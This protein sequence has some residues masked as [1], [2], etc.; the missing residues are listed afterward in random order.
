M[1]ASMS[2]KMMTKAKGD[3]RMSRSQWTSTPRTARVVGIA[4]GLALL[5]GCASS[6]REAPPAPEGAAA[7]QAE[8]PQEVR[9]EA[10]Q[11]AAVREAYERGVRDVL[12]DYRGRMRASE[13]FVY[14]PPVIEYV[15]MPAEIRSG[16]LYPSRSEP[17][18]I[19]PGG[20]RSQQGITVPATRR[21]EGP[22]GG[23]SE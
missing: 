21:D 13:H 10:A 15:D 18:I 20:Y 5:T 7:Q 2:L 3:D 6:P 11:D 12:E 4:A 22:A 14:E 9:D 1:A 23:F 8:T 19:S 17:V 16:A